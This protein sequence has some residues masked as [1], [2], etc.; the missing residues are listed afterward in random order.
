MTRR[1]VTTLLH[2]QIFVGRGFS[3]DMRRPHQQG[4]L[5]PE[6]LRHVE[7]QPGNIGVESRKSAQPQPYLSDFTIRANLLKGH[8]L[9]ISC[10][11]NRGWG[12]VRAQGKCGIND[13]AVGSGG[14]HELL[15]L[16]GL[17]SLGENYNSWPACVAPTVL[18]ILMATVP[19]PTGWATLCRASGTLAFSGRFGIFSR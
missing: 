18:A 6:V 14:Q 11:V 15:H 1:L 12:E 17:E 3:R 9:A 19:S 2:Q 4:A 16:Q 8:G 5:A 7:P 13:T 10:R